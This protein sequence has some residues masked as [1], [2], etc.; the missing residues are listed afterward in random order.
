M[1]QVA[2]LTTYPI[3]SC[4]G[5]PLD[6]AQVGP[7]GLL[8][9]RQWMLVDEK[10]RFVTGRL[11]P[12]LVSIKPAMDARQL[13]VSAPGATPLQVPIPE[14]TER[15]TVTVWS[16]TVSALDA[17]DE[18]AAWF[19]HVCGKS[20][21][22]VFADAAMRRP[23]SANH[24]VSEHDEVAFPDGYP[25]LLLSESA[26]AQ[27][28]ERVGRAMDARRFRANVLI[29]NSGAHAEDN[30]RRIRIGEVELAVVKPCVRCVFTTV[31]PDRAERE[32]DGEPLVTLKRYRAVEKGVIFG[33]NAIP[34]THGTIRV[35]DSIEV[36]V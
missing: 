30:W 15:V 23:V 10:K 4:A 11:L 6:A 9:D 20:L 12:T 25:I 19:S 14:S 18:A 31:D 28:S 17:G 2:A 1:L 32:P 5:V 7:R 24:A 26:V 16:D 27:L 8:G 34:I 13:F 29:A 3:K 21:R 33:M 22:L 35:H 36:L